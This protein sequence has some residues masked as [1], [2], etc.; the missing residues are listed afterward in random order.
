MHSDLF[1]QVSEKVEWQPFRKGIN[2]HQAEEIVHYDEVQC[3]FVIGIN[4][5]RNKLLLLNTTSFVNFD[6]ARLKQRYIRDKILNFSVYFHNS[7]N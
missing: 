3:P 5:Q 2:L 1:W 4:G 7:E 6:L